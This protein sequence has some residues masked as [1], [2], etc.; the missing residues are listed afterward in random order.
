M[1]RQSPEKKISN[2]FPEPETLWP[3]VPTGFV[4]DK[5]NIVITLSNQNVKQVE[6]FVDMDGNISEDAAIAWNVN[7]KIGYLCR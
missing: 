4:K 7:R 1:A 3:D 2:F 5:I 6:D